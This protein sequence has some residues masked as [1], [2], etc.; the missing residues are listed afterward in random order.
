[1]DGSSHFQL[2]PSEMVRI[3]LAAEYAEYKNRSCE[4][5]GRH[6]IKLDHLYV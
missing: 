6:G 5:T 2:L 4:F 1:L 3:L